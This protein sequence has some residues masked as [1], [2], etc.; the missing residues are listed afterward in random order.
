MGK[1]RRNTKY[2]KYASIAFLVVFL[3]SGAL[4]FVRVW[5]S[6]QSDFSEQDTDESVILY[7]GTEY[8][9]R[10]NVETFLVLGLDKFS[11]DASADSWV[12]I[13]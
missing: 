3:I 1:H 2:I 13:R 5:E 9:F 4:L 10:D 11:G 12:S 8:V 6:H 7:N